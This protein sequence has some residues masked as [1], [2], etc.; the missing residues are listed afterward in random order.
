L[1]SNDDG[2]EKR[3][4]VL[5][6]NT[7]NDK[8]TKKEENLSTMEFDPNEDEGRN[9]ILALLRTQQMLNTMREQQQQQQQHLRTKSTKPP[10]TST[11]APAAIVKEAEEDPQD[12]KPDQAVRNAV[13]LKEGG[14]DCVSGDD[15][16]TTDNTATTSNVAGAVVTTSSSSH[17]TGTA[18]G[19]GV[20]TRPPRTRTPRVRSIGYVAAKDSRTDFF[21]RLDP[22][23]GSVCARCV[24]DDVG[25][26][27]R[28][29]CE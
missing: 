13:E 12:S 14:D 10:S 11:A 6:V 25:A 7:Q 16:P 18:P 29:Y 27:K 8:E 15:G 17:L 4:D 1:W 28:A 23:V 2:D 22:K 5:C 21:R 3:I 26:P 19:G 24:Q 20:R 9:Q